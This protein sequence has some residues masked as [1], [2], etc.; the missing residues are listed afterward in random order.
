MRNRSS[1]PLEEEEVLTEEAVESKYQLI[2]YND[3]VNTFEYVTETLIKICR[4]D[5]IQA[6]QCTWLIHYTGK[7]AVKEGSFTS[8]EPM[9]TA[10]LQRGISATIES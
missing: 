7:C 6:E 3:D 10:I 5:P 9:C 1:K 4:H 8:L 2:L